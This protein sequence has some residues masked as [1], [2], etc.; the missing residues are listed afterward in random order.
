MAD[1]RAR[2][3]VARPGS[4]ADRLARRT[5]EGCLLVFIGLSVAI[6]SLPLERVFATTP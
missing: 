1:D 6:T 2:H 3:G 5:N 4:C